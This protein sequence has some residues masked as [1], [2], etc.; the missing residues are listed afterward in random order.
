MSAF[1]ALLFEEENQ[2][3]CFNITVAAQLIGVSTSTIRRWHRDGLLDFEPARDAVGR[4]LYS[5]RQL[6]ELETLFRRLHHGGPTVGQKT[7]GSK[8]NCAT[9]VEGALPE[10]ELR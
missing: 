9:G 3:R 6:H 8:W 1:L 4:R 5:R 7:A 2:M 10:P